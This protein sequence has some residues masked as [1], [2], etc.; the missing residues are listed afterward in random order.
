M[1]SLPCLFIERCVFFCYCV[2]SSHD[3]VVANS[4]FFSSLVTAHILGR[5][6]STKGGPCW[7]CGVCLVYVLWFLLLGIRSHVCSFKCWSCS[8]RS[9]DTK[10]DPDK[11]AV[12]WRHSC[13]GPCISVQLSVAAVFGF[14]DLR[15]FRYLVVCLLGAAL[16]ATTF[17]SFR[18]S[19]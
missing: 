6:M 10:P 13:Y 3:R 17:P 1:G 11:Y 4:W 7:R 18:D 8:V 16:F 12:S 19:Y 9:N 2:L 14:F 5:W 15:W